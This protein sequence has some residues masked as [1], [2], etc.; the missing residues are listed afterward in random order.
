MAHRTWGYLRSDRVKFR[1][2]VKVVKLK[3]KFIFS[4]K[5]ENTS[6]IEA[7]AIKMEKNGFEVMRG[8]M[9]FIFLK[10]GQILSK[11]YSIKL[12]IVV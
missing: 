2:S 4:S 9:K 6:Q 10:V 11:L 1:P 3:R 5:N 8:H 12:I 7:V